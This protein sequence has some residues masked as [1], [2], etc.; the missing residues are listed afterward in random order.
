MAGAGD[1]LDE[2]IARDIDVDTGA[3]TRHAV[4]IDG[5]AM[6]D[7]LKRL[8]GG[9][10]DGARR[11]AVAGGDKTDAAGVMFHF[12]PVD[13]GIGQTRLVAGPAGQIGGVIEFHMIGHGPVQC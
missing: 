8:D 13:T 3:V 11:L 1:M 6:P 9:L 12:G 2:E 4:S 5:A 7:R 10:D